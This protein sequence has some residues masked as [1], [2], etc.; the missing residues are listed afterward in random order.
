VSLSNPTSR[1]EN[2][3]N[4]MLYLENNFIKDEII[5]AFCG[6]AIDGR[7]YFHVVSH[8]EP[9]CIDTVLFLV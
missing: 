2:L 4:I 1:Q 5:R 8:T 6:L 7:T 3:I 9:R